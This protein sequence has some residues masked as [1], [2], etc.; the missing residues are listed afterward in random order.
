V[1]DIDVHRN[2]RLSEVIVSNILDSDHIQIFFYF[3]DHIR[4]R[5]LSDPVDKF[6]DCERF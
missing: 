2:I 3:L 1:Y 4:T 5:N 6:T